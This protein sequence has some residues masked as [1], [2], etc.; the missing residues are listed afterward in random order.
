VAWLARLPVLRDGHLDMKVL[1]QELDKRSCPAARGHSTNADGLAQTNVLVVVDLVNH[2]LG[3]LRDMDAIVKMVRRYGALLHVDAAQALCN[4][5]FDASE[6]DSVAVTAHKVNGPVGVSAVAMCAWY[7]PHVQRVM[8]GGSF[9]S[10]LRPGTLN[11]PGIVGFG[12]AL[13]LPRDEAGPAEAFAKLLEGLREM[14]DAVRMNGSP[15]RSN[16]RIVHMTVTGGSPALRKLDDPELVSL[17]ASKYNIMLST[18]AACGS[19]PGP[20][21]RAIA[22]T[23]PSAPNHDHEDVTVGRMFC[24][25][26]VPHTVVLDCYFHDIHAGA[27]IRPLKTASIGIHHVKPGEYK[28]YRQ[29]S[30]DAQPAHVEEA[31]APLRAAL[32]A[33]ANEERTGVSIIT[34]HC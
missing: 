2:E 24:D 7:V 1:A 20:M 17:F 13:S 14:K 6:F 33:G 30:A 23:A 18:G 25:A 15:D 10:D 26:S 34:V 31:N 32:V 21:P 4:G 29:R 19:R 11:V 5:D 27:N 12:A 28:E 9:D 3:T 16:G 22:S 8:A